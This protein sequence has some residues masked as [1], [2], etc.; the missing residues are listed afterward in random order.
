MNQKLPKIGAA[1]LVYGVVTG[2]SVAVFHGQGLG[3][4]LDGV[5]LFG[6]FYYLTA[7]AR[8]RSS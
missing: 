8:E 4:F 2:T 7:L 1:I 5:L 6:L 3:L